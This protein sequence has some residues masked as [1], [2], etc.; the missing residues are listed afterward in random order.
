MRDLL[1]V[2]PSRRPHNVARLWE[3]MQRT[4][5]GDTTL[6]VGIDDDD[7]KRD[8]YPLPTYP[9]GKIDGPYAEIAPWPGS[10]VAWI[11]K[12]AIP[13]TDKYQFI[14]HIGDDVLPRTVGW[15]VRVMEALG[16]TPF[17]HANDLYALRPPGAL[18][19]HVFC[20]SEVISALGYFGL[21]T[22][23]SQY[24]DD[25]WTAWGHACGITF[26]EDV[27]LEHMHPSVGKAPFDEI[28]ARSAANMP[29]GQQAFLA[30]CRDALAADI[31][32]IR[33]VTDV[34]H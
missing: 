34:H 26:L 21:P 27:V 14:G 13:R 19:C 9:D 8:D 33:A 25:A 18:A 29:Q 28:Y 5:R 1:V 20:R 12:L 4:C 24:V 10:I 32:K 31:A 16:K 2:L 23:K 22:L 17:V 11:N 6:L 30:Y 3:A 15:D 7:P